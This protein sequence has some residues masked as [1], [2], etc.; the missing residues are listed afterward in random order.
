VAVGPARRA[1][2]AAD[3]CAEAQRVREA[4][5]AGEGGGDEGPE[6]GVPVRPQSCAQR[7]PCGVPCDGLGEERGAVLLPL[8]QGAALPRLAVRLAAEGESHR[9]RGGVARD[10]LAAVPPRR[11]DVAVEGRV[12]AIEEVLVVVAAEAQA[13]LEAELGAGRREP[14]ERRRGGPGL[15]VLVVRRVGRG[16]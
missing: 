16:V 4:V 14:G 1:E 9:G 7:C 8:A 15:L 2:R 12:V 10:E 13:R 3:G 11:V 6:G 5:R